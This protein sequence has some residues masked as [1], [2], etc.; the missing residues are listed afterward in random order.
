[1]ES[2]RILAQDH[3]HEAATTNN[4]ME[5]TALI[6]ACRV[7]PEDAAVTVN[8]DSQ[9]AVNTIT[10]WAPKWEKKGW[11]RKGPPLKNLDLVKELLTLHRA[12]ARCKLAWIAAHRGYRWNEYAD[13]LATAWMRDSL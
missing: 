3:G 7:L 2:G 12:H 5:L 4:R 9:L 6:A 11:T 10:K 1:M 13:S 8:S